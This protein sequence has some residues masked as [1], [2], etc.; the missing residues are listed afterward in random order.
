M[1]IL[2]SV[3]SILLGFVAGALLMLSSGANPLTGFSY[4][5]QGA[6]GVTRICNTIAYAV[7]LMLTGLSV[8]F[9]FKTGLFNIGAPGQML[10]GACSPM[11]WPHRRLPGRCCCRSSSPRRSS[12]A[13]CGGGPRLLTARFNVNEVVSC[14]MMNWVAYWV[15]YIVITDHF[16]STTIDTESQVIPAAASLKTEAITLLT[17]GSNLNL[18]IF[19][20]IIATALV[21]FILNRTVLG[22]EMKAVGFNR[23]AA[24]YGGIN[25]QKNA[26]LA[27]VI[28]GALSGLAGLTF[29]CGYLSN[30]R[31]GVMP[32]QGFDGI[33]VALLA[34]CAPVGVVF[35][36]IFFAILQTGKG[37]MNAMMPIPPEIADTI[38]ATVI[39]FAATSK[40]IEMNLD[41]I[42]KFFGR[43]RP[44][45][46]E[47][48]G[49]HVEHH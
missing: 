16:K 20:A 49:E 8:T 38:I 7:P 32:S 12:A 34:N 33:A 37:F 44:S 35:A 25:V 39:Y 48:S 4:L 18:G 13:W 41:R 27:M 24:E 30:M 21:I 1:K 23:F 47:G 36:A 22:Y 2:V 42:K 3:I 28:S 14:I 15:V 40:L 6:Q 5:F 19:I 45:K 10:I 29:Y 31:I 17:K 9:A 26:V 46:S 43:K 11:C